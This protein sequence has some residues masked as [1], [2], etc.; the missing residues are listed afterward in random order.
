[1]FTWRLLIIMLGLTKQDNIHEKKRQNFLRFDTLR[2]SKR[3]Y[4][5]PVV[6]CNTMYPVLSIQA[7]LS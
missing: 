3:R 1:M 5:F 6:I 7:K 2:C 4:P